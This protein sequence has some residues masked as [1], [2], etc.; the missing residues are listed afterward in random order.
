MRGT[1]S[2]RGGQATKTAACLPLMRSCRQRSC[3]S[4]YQ[5]TLSP[6]WAPFQGKLTSSTSASHGKGHRY[7]RRKPKPNAT[8][9]FCDRENSNLG[10]ASGGGGHCLVHHSGHV[11]RPHRL[12]SLRAQDQ[13]Y[14]EA[15]ATRWQ[16]GSVTL[17]LH[18]L[19]QVTAPL[20][21]KVASYMR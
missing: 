12:L 10:L 13:S 17:W 18:D 6:T 4:R 7:H 11:H 14:Q 3:L 15:I 8:H 19:R 5:G 1:E 2:A 21:A 16:M 9:S 20:W